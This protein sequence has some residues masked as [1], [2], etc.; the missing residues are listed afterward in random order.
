[1]AVIDLFDFR[2]SDRLCGIAQRQTT[3][4]MVW[5]D[6]ILLDWVTCNLAKS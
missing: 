3:P 6:V 4:L 5:A 1:M 2:T